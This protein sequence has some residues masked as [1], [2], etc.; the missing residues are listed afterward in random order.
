VCVCVYVCVCMCVG[1]AGVRRLKGGKTEFFVDE[2]CEVGQWALA[3]LC[4]YVC[5][6]L[7]ILGR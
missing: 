2:F 3:A 4:V 7:C 5:M 1:T 6:Y